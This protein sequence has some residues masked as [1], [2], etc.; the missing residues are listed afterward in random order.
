MQMPHPMTT[1]SEVM[2]KLRLK[3]LDT[4]MRWTKE[5][6]SA[7]KGKVY[8][9]DELEIIKVYRFEGMSD[10]SDT[11]ILYLIKANDGLIGYSIDAYGAY[12]NHDN[13]EGYDNFIRLIPETG[14]DQQL[15][16]EL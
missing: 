8:Q 4:E 9:P 7:G 12:S 1:L 3:G 11:S 6:F 15:S 13:E 5:G 14:H 2:E 16:F 10:P